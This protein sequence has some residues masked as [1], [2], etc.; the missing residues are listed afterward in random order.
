MA[1][2]LID[3]TD[4]YKFVQYSQAIPEPTTTASFWD[5]QFELDI[6][7]EPDFDC[8]LGRHEPK[9]YYNSKEYTRNTMNVVTGSKIIENSDTMQLIRVLSGFPYNQS[10]FQEPRTI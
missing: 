3:G 9:L 6:T 7:Y 5:E 4:T 10:A 1:P 8:Y 2:K